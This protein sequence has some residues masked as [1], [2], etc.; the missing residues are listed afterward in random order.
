MNPGALPTW[1]SA[2][3]SPG[4]EVEKTRAVPQSPVLPTR[5]RPRP[6]GERVGVR[7]GAVVF[8]EKSQ[9]FNGM[10]VRLRIR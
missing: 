2:D 6:N 8:G 9:S 5:D 1:P 7:G 4:G 3:L 10:G